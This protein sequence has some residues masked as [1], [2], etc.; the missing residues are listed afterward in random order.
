MSSTRRQTLSTYDECAE[1]FGCDPSQLR[2]KARRLGLPARYE[3][4]GPGAKSRVFT[5]AEVERLRPGKR[6]RPRNQ[7]SISSGDQARRR[8]AASGASETN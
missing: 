2:A 8:A 7:S 6:G 4:R 5:R 3:Q 1:L